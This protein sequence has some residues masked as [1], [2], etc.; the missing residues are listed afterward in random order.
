MAAQPPNFAPVEEE[1]RID[2]WYGEEQRFGLLG[3]PVPAI[4]ILGNVSSTSGQAITILEYSLNGGSRKVLSIGP[5]R[6]R[7]AE[8]GDFNIDIP[9]DQL[10][11]GMNTVEI[12]ARDD[13]G[14]EVMSEVVTH[15]IPDALWPLPFTADW[16]MGA[17]QELTWVVDGL[18]AVESGRLRTMQVG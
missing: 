1:I 4:N 3:V 8:P 10:L 17:P 5:D 15:F 12:V 18:W 14:H 13:A 16:S 6:R 2:V 11:D 7:L 9:I